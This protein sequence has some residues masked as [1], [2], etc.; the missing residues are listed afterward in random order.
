MPGM[1]KKLRV[2]A[3]L[4][5]AG[6]GFRFKEMV[7]K[8]FALL[9]GR[10]LFSYSLKTL[11]NSAIFDELIVVCHRDWIKE[12]M[13]YPLD[14][15][16]QVVPGGSSRQQSSYLGLIAF[17]TPPDIVLIHDA[18]RPFLT[19]SQMEKTLDAAIEIG[20]ATVSLPTTDTLVISKEGKTIQKIVDR[21][22]YFRVATPQAFR[23][24]LLIKAHHKAQNNQ[25]FSAT[26]D[27]S[28]IQ[29]EGHPVRLVDGAL[30]NLKITLKEDL[31]M[32]EALLQMGG[33]H[34]G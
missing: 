17:E 26:D 1:Y 15:S 33:F 18:A 30:F 28:L 2:G 12:L 8:Q 19:L 24:P 5:M 29:Q 22:H 23:Y 11:E 34:D 6:T 4:L 21:S 16:I 27:C 20:A 14:A 32:A 3:L 25:D 10:P 9:A 31:K 7:P 13:R